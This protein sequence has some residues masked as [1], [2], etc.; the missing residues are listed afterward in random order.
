MLLNDRLLNRD[1]VSSQDKLEL[2]WES[3]ESCHGLM[4]TDGSLQD[5]CLHSNLK[6]H[7]VMKQDP[8]KWMRGK[9]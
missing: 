4:M 6:L 5:L 3:L 7:F 1:V 8:P 2:L 9:G